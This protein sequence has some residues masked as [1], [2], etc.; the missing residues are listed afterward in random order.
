MEVDWASGDLYDPPS[1]ALGSE[2]VLFTSCISIDHFAHACTFYTTF[3]PSFH[4]TET[5]DATA[6]CLLSLTQVLPTPTQMAS[7]LP[8]GPRSGLCSTTIS[9]TARRSRGLTFSRANEVDARL[10]LTFGTTLHLLCSGGLKYI[11]LQ[12][13]VVHDLPVAP[14]D[15]LYI[16]S[17]HSPLHGDWPALGCKAM[18]TT[19][20]KKTL[21]IP[22][23]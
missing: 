15:E 14:N 5:A 23:G 11:L 19:T 20:G 2:D 16:A 4:S 3:Q 7:R 12:A 21:P 10:T 18:V 13:S 8:Q 9:C 6:F 17:C 1:G 22:L